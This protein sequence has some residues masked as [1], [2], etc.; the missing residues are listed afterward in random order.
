M[1][2]YKRK[3]YKQGLV[4]LL[5]MHQGIV[6]TNLLKSLSVEQVFLHKAE[7]SLSN[8]CCYCHDLFECNTVVWQKGIIASVHGLVCRTV[9]HS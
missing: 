5:N 1:G 4:I 7:I 8:H 6:P 3:G 2:T 9:S